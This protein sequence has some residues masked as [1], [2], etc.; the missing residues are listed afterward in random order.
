MAESLRKRLAMPSNP[1]LLTKE[2]NQT[3][4]PSYHSDPQCN[5]SMNLK[6]IWKKPF[7]SQCKYLETVRGITRRKWPYILSKSVWISSVARKHPF[8]LEPGHYLKFWR[9]ALENVQIS[10][11]A[12]ISN[13]QE[14]ILFS[15]NWALSHILNAG[16]GKC[17]NLICWMKISNVQEN[18]LFL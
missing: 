1:I 17:L 5:A 12:K 16:P 7:S 4:L 9:Q 8:F 6:N 2:K 3:R 13:A 15:K 14:N 18:I 11:H 10:F